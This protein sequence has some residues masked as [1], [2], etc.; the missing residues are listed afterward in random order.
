MELAAVAATLPP[1]LCP[2]AQF[3]NWRLATASIFNA[4][5]LLEDYKTSFRGELE[6]YNLERFLIGT[7]RSSPLTTC[8][9]EILVG[10]VGVDHLLFQLY[11]SGEA[12]F[13]AE[14]RAGRV[15][16]GD[17]VCF[18]LSRR[19]RATL[20]DVHAV[21]LVVPRSL[22]LLPPR[23]L[24]IAH[25]AT[26]PGESGLGALL[27]HQIIGLGDCVPRLA[28]SEVG[29]AATLV[30]AIINVALSNC[31][32]AQIEDRSVPFALSLQAVR[33]YID[34]HICEPA[35]TPEMISRQLGISRSA[36]YRIFEPLGGISDY[37]RDR[38][39]DRAAL[40]LASVG[41]GRGAVSRLSFAVGFASE[42]TFSRAF[43]GR[44]GL[45]PREA[46]MRA[47]KRS[48]GIEP[49]LEDGK[50]NWIH[51]WLESLSASRT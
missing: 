5:P 22:I 6:T 26:I 1:D 14:G 36:L 4:R 19:H 33:A 38:R 2:E 39:L 49:G 45:S 21:S 51:G 17:L 41:L 47:G 10:A 8:R 27:S 29:P 20:T 43:R 44:Y 15:G 35:L 37:I 30:E 46:I 28:R 31:G 7:S 25:G 50:R 12:E 9:D 48:N 13:D 32:R 11:L 18:D 23:A 24:D 34:D 42:A 40:H 16:P 3:E